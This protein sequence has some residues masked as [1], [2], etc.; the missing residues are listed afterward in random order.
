M[1]ILMDKIC[2]CCRKLKDAEKDF[3][4]EYKS[5]GIRAPR[6]KACQAE[7][8]KQHYQQNKAAYN[9]RSHVRKAGIRNGNQAKLHA[10]LMTHPC[11]DCGQTDMTLLEFDHVRG[12]KIDRVSQL[13]SKGHNWPI[14]EAEI[15]K[16][17]VRCANCHRKK[18][19]ERA[20][21]W[22]KA[23]VIELQAD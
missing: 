7:L 19:F 8:G 12:E 10:Y 14:L 17:E 16:C 22:W 21:N 13:L 11:I 4:W 9:S 15:A 2:S 3:S 5:R 6:C 1:T 18:T 20:G 23:E